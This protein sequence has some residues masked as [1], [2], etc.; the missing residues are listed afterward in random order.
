MEKIR[1]GQQFLYRKNGLNGTVLDIRM[2]NNVRGD[3]LQMALTTTLQ[4]YPYISNKLVEKDGNYYLEESLIS[5]NVIKTNSFRELGSMRIG[6]HLVDITYWGNSIR[7]AFHHALCDGRGIK[8]F[9]ETLI[10]YYCCLRFNKS[11]EPVGIRL[12][13]DEL[14]PGETQEP[15]CSSPYEVD[16][17]LVPQVTKDGYSLPENATAGDTYYRYEV[18]MN[19]QSFVDCMKSCKATP[20][21]LLALLVSESIY[22]VHPEAVKPIVC[23]MAIDFRKE[24]GLDNT[25]KNCVGSLYLTYSAE[26]REMDMTDQASLYRNLLREQ[27]QPEAIKNLFNV[28]IGLSSKLDQIPTLEEKKQMLSFFNDLCIDTYVISSLGKIQLGEWE[29]HVDSVH[30]YN[31]GV[32]G[33]R[34][35]MTCAGEYFTV[36]VLQN[37][38][39][40]DL[41][42]ALRATL[43][44]AGIEHSVSERIQFETVKDKAYITA[45]RQPERYYKKCSG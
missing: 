15:V 28:Q 10:Y 33:L 41:I 6:Y 17:N 4:R 42:N 36:D 34:I 25:H 27:R 39:S 31:S 32:N 38:Q 45:S 23:S 16:R 5:M 37:F 24:L 21:T 2:K 43:S 7:I 44:A 26:T 13:G 11:F 19:R 40:E 22:S 20:A 8:P 30:L 35:N 1:S 9:M 12:A 3:L 14:L 29:K 18:A